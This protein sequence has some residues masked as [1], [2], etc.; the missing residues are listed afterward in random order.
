[1]K[2]F[3]SVPIR[4]G[5][6][7]LKISGGMI[8]P[9]LVCAAQNCVYNNG[10]YCSKGDIKVGGEN[11]TVC[12]D[13][14]CESFQER[15]YESVKSSVGTPSVEIRIKCEAVNCKYNHNRVCHAKHVD[16]SGAAANKS[17]ET[18]CVTFDEE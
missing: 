2:P 1:M 4:A 18:E 8:M 11:A 12:Q 14:C 9:A 15:R 10:M 3:D 13:T 7:K 5:A 16:I 17:S 6:A